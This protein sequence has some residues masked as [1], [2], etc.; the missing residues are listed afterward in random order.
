METEFEKVRKYKNWLM[1]KACG[2]S[3]AIL[4]AVRAVIWLDRITGH[5][6][7]LLGL[8]VAL[9]AFLYSVMVDS[10][11]HLRRR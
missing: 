3:L 9:W 8:F 4:L 6:F 1:L 10:D 7:L 11:P 5:F 2:I